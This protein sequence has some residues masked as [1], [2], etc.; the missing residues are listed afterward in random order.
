MNLTF[1]EMPAVKGMELTIQKGTN[2]NLAITCLS[3]A[4]VSTRVVRGGIF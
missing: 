2:G 1:M 4:I 3:A